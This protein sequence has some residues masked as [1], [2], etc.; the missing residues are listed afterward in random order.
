MS[1]V[2]Y[3]LINFLF[4][5]LFVTNVAKFHLE[6]FRASKNWTKFVLRIADAQCHISQSP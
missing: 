1:R 2:F 3:I 5:E 4:D 6:L